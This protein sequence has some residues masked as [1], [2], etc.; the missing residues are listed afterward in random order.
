MKIENIFTKE[1]NLENEDKETRKTF[2]RSSSSKK[3]DP[4]SKQWPMYHNIW[5]SLN[6]MFNFQAFNC[7]FC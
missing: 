4:E 3:I 1:H 7:C 2:K 6:L 5:R